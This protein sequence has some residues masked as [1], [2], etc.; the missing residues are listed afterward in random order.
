MIGS[1][2]K[3]QKEDQEDRGLLCR[4]SCSPI[5]S[6]G[7]PR[8]PR[9]PVGPQGSD[10]GQFWEFSCLDPIGGPGR[11]VRNIKKAFMRGKFN[12]VLLFFTKLLGGWFYENLRELGGEG[13]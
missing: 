11:P 1:P 2:G 6:I 12:I 3:R 5:G 13:H 7:A 4:G 8:E 9:N 10:F